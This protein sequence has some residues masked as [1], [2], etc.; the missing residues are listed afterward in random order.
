VSGD[1]RWRRHSS[2]TETDGIAVQNN[3]NTG[4]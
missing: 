1:Q 4:P 3:T 2:A